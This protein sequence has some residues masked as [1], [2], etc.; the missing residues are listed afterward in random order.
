[1]QE[2]R[3]AIGLIALCGQLAG[4]ATWDPALVPPTDPQDQVSRVQVENIVAEGDRV[5]V[6]LADTDKVEGTIVAIDAEAMAVR[7]GA[8]SSSSPTWGTSSLPPGEDE[9]DQWIPRAS[10]LRIERHN[11]N[12]GTTIAILAVVAVVA[13]IIGKSIENSLDWG[14]DGVLGPN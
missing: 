3:K 8:P 10:I 5:R 2:Y 4:C 13:V 12:D 7:T 1:M 11:S 14:D 6:T 9:R